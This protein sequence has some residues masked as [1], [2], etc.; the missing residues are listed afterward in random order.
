M[1]G[2]KQEIKLL[3]A[4]P[5]LRAADYPRSRAFYRDV[6]GF[7]VVEEGGTPPRF[8]IFERDGAVLFVDSWHGGPP[9]V[10]GGWHAYLHVT[11]LEALRDAFAAAGAEITREIEHTVYDMREFELTDPDGNVLCFGEDPQ[12]SG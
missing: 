4:T 5:V 12:D 10:S 7:Q 9:E 8:G 3:R 11:G 2:E 6:L 1:F